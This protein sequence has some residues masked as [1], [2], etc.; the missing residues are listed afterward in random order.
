M[1]SCQKKEYPSWKVTSRSLDLH[2]Y[3]QCRLQ[4]ARC[5]HRDDFGQD[6]ILLQKNIT[7]YLKQSVFAQLLN[8]VKENI[9]NIFYLFTY[10][11]SWPGVFLNVLLF[12]GLVCVAKVGLGICYDLRFSELSLAL[13]RSG[14]EILTYPSAFTVATGAAHWEVRK[15]V[16]DDKKKKKTVLIFV[17]VS[18]VTPRSGNRDPVLRLGSSPGRP[19]PWE[20]RVLWSQPGSGPLGRGASWLWRGE[21][22]SGASRSRL[23]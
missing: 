10:E 23:G 8:E 16:N 12:P 2:L 6:W 5:I 11:V 22:C 9:S 13:Q 21:P 4:L 14:A 17:P 20:A 7:F 1:W 3:P 15:S 19:T 18:G